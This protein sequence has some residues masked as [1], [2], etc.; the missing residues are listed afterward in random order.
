MTAGSVGEPATLTPSDRSSSFPIGQFPTHPQPSGRAPGLR[1]GPRRSQASI[2]TLYCPKGA[3]TLRY[4]G[5]LTTPPCSEVVGLGCNGRAVPGFAGTG[6]C[7]RG[8][9]SDERASGPAA[10]PPAVHSHEVGTR[11]CRAAGRATG[12][13]VGDGPR[14]PRWPPCG[15]AGRQIRQRQTCGARLGVPFPSRGSEGARPPA[16]PCRG[17]AKRGPKGWAGSP[18]LAEKTVRRGAQSKAVGITMILHGEARFRSCQPPESRRF[19]KASSTVPEPHRPPPAAP[20]S[21]PG[22]T[23]RRV[24]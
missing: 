19:P 1:K 2:R 13:Q 14:P 12:D 24:T 15:R 4:A 20:P 8:V 17:L 7:L 9:V 22:A 23:Y 21:S 5:S 6:R 11:T 10:P 3:A 18:A 16:S